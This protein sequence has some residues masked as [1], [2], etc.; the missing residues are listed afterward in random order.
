MTRLVD[1]FEILLQTVRQAFP[2]HRTFEHARRLP[3]GFAAAWG[4]RTISRALCATH[5]QFHD[6][7]ATYRFFSRSP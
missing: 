7:S 2:Q 5:D 1:A 3:Y 4:R 6:W